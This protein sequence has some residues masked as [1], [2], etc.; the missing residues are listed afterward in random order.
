M[1]LS[2]QDLGSL[3]DEVRSCGDAIQSRANQVL[4]TAAAFRLRIAATR[5][6]VS[7]S[8][9]IQ[10]EDLPSLLA[11]VDTDLEIFEA[12]RREAASA[13]SKLSADLQSVTGDLGAI[14]TAIQFHDITRQQVEH[15]TQALAGLVR[16]APSR[17][18]SPSAAAL[19]LLQE[20]QLKS[21][22]AAF[23]ESTR[24]ID[25]D[26]EDIAVRVG[27]MAAA[28]KRILG[29]D[30][31]EKNSF[32]SDME[33]RFAG[34]L[35]AAGESQSLERSTGSIVA[36]L[37]GL[38]Q[39]LR[40]AV[41]EV[42]AIELQLSRISLNGAISA[43]HIGAP[44]EPLNV[45]AGAMQ[46]LYI[47]CA[48]RSREAE[49]DLDSIGGAIL[50]LASD[51]RNSDDASNARVFDDL[52]SRMTNLRSANGASADAAAAV[53]ALAETLCKN[54]REA[55][56]HSGIGHV[57]ADIVNRFCGVLHNV[58]AQAQPLWPFGASV[59][60]EVREERYTMRA[61][62]DVHQAVTGGLAPLPLEAVSHAASVESEEEVEFF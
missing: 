14:A 52:K 42:Q 6:E 35:R 44:G 22:A 47:E 40:A 8:D 36:D 34:I 29:L 1:T 17:W 5:R 20:A 26:L 33:R 45:V 57:F 58:A 2:G 12:R 48:S 10:Q 37:N 9:A 15:V 11:A 53:A 18:I 50:S 60:E 46:A 61:E 32:L 13:S 27:E 51:T 30:Q 41:S 23:A 62:R 54:L 28:S 31:Q 49:T 59:I 38:S 25:R 4:E 56:D 39:R 55:R 43:S 3:S 19:V 16:D 21:A 24:K 7:R